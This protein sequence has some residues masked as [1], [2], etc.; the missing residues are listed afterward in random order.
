MDVRVGTIIFYFL[1]M[2]Q[3]K[4]FQ[5]IIFNYFIHACMHTYVHTHSNNEEWFG[6]KLN[7]YPTLVLTKSER[8]VMDNKMKTVL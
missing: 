3:G 1:G 2:R 7:T 5:N 8:C 4:A 6:A